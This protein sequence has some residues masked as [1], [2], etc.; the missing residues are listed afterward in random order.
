MWIIIELFKRYSV[1]YSYTLNKLTF[2]MK[3]TKY[4]GLTTAVDHI[5][6]EIRLSAPGVVLKA[7]KLFSPNSSSIAR[8][9]AVYQSPESPDL[10]P[11]LTSDKHHRLQQLGCIL[12]Y[13]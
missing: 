1:V 11:L 3:A 9:P 4:H 10:F 13:Y 6:R 8:S 2:K 5:A 12:I 7:L